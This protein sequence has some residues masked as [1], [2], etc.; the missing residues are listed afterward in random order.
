[1]ITETRDVTIDDIRN[2]SNDEKLK[3]VDF[4]VEATSHEAHELWAKWFHYPLRN[5]TNDP[6]G[7]K[8]LDWIQ[9]M[10]GFSRVVGHIKDDL[11]MPVCISFSFYII[12]GKYVCFY[13][14]VSRYVDYTMVEEYISKNFPLK[15]DNS[16][17]RRMT[18]ASN[19]SNCIWW[20]RK[21]Y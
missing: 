3:A 18:N 11:D 8:P 12:N 20:C 9:D 4:F 1:M 6:S 21:P 13:E 17:R 10:S 5:D 14:A 19:F 16:T 15:Y 2:M 7:E